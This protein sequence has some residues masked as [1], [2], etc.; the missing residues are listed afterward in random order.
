MQLW[1]TVVS[2]RRQIMKL[3]QVLADVKYELIQG[4]LEKEVADIAYDSRKV[5]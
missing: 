2:D 1:G 5:K 4:S 3:K